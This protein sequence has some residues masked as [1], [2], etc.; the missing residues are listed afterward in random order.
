MMTMQWNEPTD[1]LDLMR[2]IGPDEEED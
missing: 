2:Q 1:D